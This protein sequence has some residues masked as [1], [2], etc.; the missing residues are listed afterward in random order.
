MGPS[1]IFEPLSVTKLIKRPDFYPL[2]EWRPAIVDRLRR[3]QPATERGRSG[4]SRR[5][6]HHRAEG[7]QH[8][9]T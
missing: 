2:A 5:A 3:S 8:Q 1:N 6:A 7:D 9:R 4:W